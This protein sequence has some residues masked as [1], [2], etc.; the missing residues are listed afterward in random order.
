LLLHGKVFSP[1]FRIEAVGDVSKLTKSLRDDVNV[2]I[3]QDYVDLFGL[4]FEV[5]RAAVIEL[6]PY[7]GSLLLDNVQI[8]KNIL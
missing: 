5:Q 4:I 8:R 1:P 7:E 6:P 2:A 3:L